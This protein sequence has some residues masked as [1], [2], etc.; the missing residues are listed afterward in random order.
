MAGVYNGLDVWLR[1]LERRTPL[2]SEDRRRV[3]ALPGRSERIRANRDFVRLGERVSEICLI[4]RGIAARFGQTRDGRRQLTA[5]H[6]A[7]DA[8]DLH[9]AVL[10]NAGSALSALSDVV[11]YRIP[12]PAIHEAV[13]ASP[14]LA[15]AMWRDC[16]VDASIAAEWLV[17][18][19]QRDGRTR[20]AHLICE[21]AMRFAAVGANRDRFMLDLSQAHLGDALGLTSVHVNRML[22]EL[23]EAGLVAGVGRHIEIPDWDRLAS[24]ADF[25]PRYLHLHREHPDVGKS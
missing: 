25:D 10:P 22:R 24:A 5:L 9:S 13:R 1:R 2:S 11:I 21:L 16:T 14:A 20:L 6:I 18:N 23:R 15:R 17:N 7:G 8:A 12:H 4:V 3:L 19:G